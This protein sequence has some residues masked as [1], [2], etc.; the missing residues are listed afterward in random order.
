MARRNDLPGVGHL[1]NSDFDAQGNPKSQ[2]IPGLDGKPLFF[3]VQ[4]SYCG[5]CKTAKPDFLKLFQNQHRKKVFIATLQTDD[6]NP[7]SQTKELM[8]RLKPI[9]LS[10]HSIK[11]QGVP[12]YLL[13]HNGQ[14]HEYEGGRDY[15]SLKKFVDTL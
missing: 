8:D 15:A 11:F 10:K 2:S 6:E 13:F 1:Q 12:T 14:Y 4:G 9:L 3:M 7:Q 5:H